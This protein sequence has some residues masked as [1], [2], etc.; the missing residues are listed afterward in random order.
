LAQHPELADVATSANAV[1]S[2]Q[3]GAYFKPPSPAPSRQE[4][5]EALRDGSSKIHNEWAI[6]CLA[7]NDGMPATVADAVKLTKDAEVGFRLRGSSTDLVSG[8]D[9]AAFAGAS[10]ASFGLGNNQVTKARTGQVIGALGY[11]QPLN[12][13]DTLGFMP[14]VGGNYNVTKTGAAATKYSSDTI[15]GGVYFSGIA[16]L[17]H[18]SVLTLALAPDYLHNFADRSS[19]LSLSS[20]ITPKIVGLLNDSR[21]VTF[22]D[23]LPSL[24]FGPSSTPTYLTP[25]A[26][27]RGDF[28]HYTNRGEGANVRT[29][30]DF[31]DLGSRFGLDIA[32]TNWYDLNIADLQQYGFSGPRRHI[33]DFESSFTYY[34]GKQSILGLTAAYKTGYLER[35]LQREDAWTLGLTAK[36]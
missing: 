28:G 7:Q 8:K 31:D 4:Y 11:F 14:Y 19:I 3:W 33:Y 34:G 16:H 35:S 24:V 5:F 26:D 36:Y 9:S 25:F 13:A 32:K 2:G 12:D 29:N 18:N 30:V 22:L 17:G 27:V 10:K 20:V 21:H 6:T 23:G 1:L 15:N